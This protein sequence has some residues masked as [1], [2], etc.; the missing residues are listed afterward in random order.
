MKSNRKR[1]Q[2]S[3]RIV[4]IV[5]EEEEY[6]VDPNRIKRFISGKKKVSVASQRNKCTTTVCVFVT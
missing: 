3:S 1:D 2:G 6:Y 4:A 5:V